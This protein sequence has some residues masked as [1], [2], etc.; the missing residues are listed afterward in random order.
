[1]S[2]HESPEHGKSVEQGELQ[3]DIVTTD[4]A[5]ER[6]NF[7]PEELSN[8]LPKWFAVMSACFVMWGFGYF[9]F[10]GVV[11][12][13]AGDQRTPIA[14]AGSGPVD[15]RVIYAANCVGCHQG[16]GLG[17]QGAFPPLAASEWVLTDPQIPAQ[18]L[19]LGMRGPIEVAGQSYSGVMP[20]MA[21]LPDD[22]LAAVLNYIRSDWGNSASEVTGDWIAEQR[23]RFTDRGP[24]EGAEELISNFGKPEVDEP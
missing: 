21:H 8:P 17:I 20:A 16:T 24:W 15:G 6:E 1:M 3:D 10:Q 11:P 19:L 13:D 18:V 9:Y 2:N 22:E 7:E 4:R 23:T 12:A 5:Y 14:P